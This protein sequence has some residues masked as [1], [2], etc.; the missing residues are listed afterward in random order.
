MREL[1][2]SNFFT[3]FRMTPELFDKLKQRVAPK[4]EKQIT[5]LRRPISV[6]ERLAGTLR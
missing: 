5:R 4:I 3:A 1:K 6:G 2:R